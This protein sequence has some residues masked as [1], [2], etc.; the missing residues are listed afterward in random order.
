MVVLKEGK[1]Y[2]Q[3]VTCNGQGNGGVGC[4]AL[5]GINENDV[6]VTI[7]CD[8]GGGKDYFYTIKCPCCGVETDI[9]SG[10]LPNSVKKLARS[11]KGLYW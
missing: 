2:I 5:L 1:G 10:L 6:Y 8:Y 9:K 3:E 4:G 7:S 11:K